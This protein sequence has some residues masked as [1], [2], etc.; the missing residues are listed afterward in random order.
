MEEVPPGER[1]AHRHDAPAVAS[2]L[3]R[4]HADVGPEPEE[5]EEQQI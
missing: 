2:V 1:E 5:Q 4:P 3:G